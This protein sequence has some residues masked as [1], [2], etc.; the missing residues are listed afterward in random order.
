VAL[1]SAN[2][3]LRD[4]TRV[5]ACRASSGVIGITFFGMNHPS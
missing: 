1:I 2:W 4:M 3:S 5:A